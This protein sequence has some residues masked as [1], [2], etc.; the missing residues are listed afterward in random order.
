MYTLSKDGYV[1]RDAD[2][3]CIPP[4]PANSDYAAYLAWVA[5]GNVA[6]PDPTAANAAW[7]AYKAQ[8]LQALNDSDI[9]VLRCYENSVPL[10]KEWADYR[11]S[12]RGIVGV[13]SGD[14]TQPLPTKPAYPAGS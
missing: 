11:K 3:A 2:N 10:P 7:D 1:I 6:T 9:V 12:L 8:A 13:S 5:E 4:D 14:P